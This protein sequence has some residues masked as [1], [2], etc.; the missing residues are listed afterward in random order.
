M[1]NKEIIVPSVKLFLITALTAL[2]LA[3]V[4]RV[5][6]P[7]IARNAEKTFQEAQAKVLPEATAFERSDLGTVEGL[8]S[9]VTINSIYVGL[10]NAQAVGY[11]VNAVC[12]E[13]YGGDISI[14][15]GISKDLTVRHVQVLEMSETPGLGAKS[16]SEEFTGSYI[17]KKSGIEVVKA[18]N[19][20]E[21]EISAISGATITS[22]AVTKAVNASLT[23]VQQSIE[24]GLDSEKITEV[25]DKIEQV[26]QETNRQLSENPPLDSNDNEQLENLR[27]EGAE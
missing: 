17:G 13:G 4:N 8:P 21:N 23:A 2:C 24:K 16:Q 14:M 9:G 6:E 7:A 15:A 10:Q 3:L 26:E 22:R 5:T 27:T 19:A 11:V 20:G 25:H 12:S 18:K 1:L